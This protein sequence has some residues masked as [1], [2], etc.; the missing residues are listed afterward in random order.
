MTPPNCA[1]WLTLAALVLSGCGSSVEPPKA[2][3]QAP[4]ASADAPSEESAT[5][6]GASD[7]E[8]NALL[9]RML[10][11]LPSGDRSPGRPKPEAAPVRPTAVLA[12]PSEAPPRPAQNAVDSF[13]E[14]VRRIREIVPRW[15]NGTGITARFLNESSGNRISLIYVDTTPPEYNADGGYWV[16]QARAKVN[17]EIVGHVMFLLKNL[18]PGRYEGSAQRKDVV[19]GS[20]LGSPTWHGRSPD[21]AWSMNEGAWVEVVLREG[22]GAGELEGNFRAKLTANDGHHYQTVESGYFYI[23]R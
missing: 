10:A 18:A 6:H 19:F 11:D 12:P 13:D 3:A 14:D 23:K 15:D 2:P 7:R 4:K 17:N 1:R 9:D 20:L 5:K 16:V 21:A 22:R 8:T